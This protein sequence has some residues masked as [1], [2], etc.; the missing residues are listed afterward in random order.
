MP[1]DA[2]FDILERSGSLL[3]KPGEHVESQLGVE[4]FLGLSFERQQTDG[5]LLKFLDA[6]GT[7]LAGRLE[8]VGHGTP[9]PVG[10]MQAA[11][12][13]SDRNGGGVRNDVD[14]IGG[15]PVIRPAQPWG[16]AAGNWAVLR[17]YR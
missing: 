12:N 9:N 2:Q 10:G 4:D 15:H 17:R 1:L 7:A 8:N 11:E 5:L 6:G 16:R 3:T 13:Q 14:G